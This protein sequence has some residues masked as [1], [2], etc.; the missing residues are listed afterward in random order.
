MKLLTLLGDYLTQRAK[1]SVFSVLA[2]IGP[3]VKQLSLGLGTIVVG[4][5]CFLFTLFF[6]SLSFFFFLI[7]HADWSAAGLWTAFVTALIGL[8]LTLVGRSILTQSHRVLA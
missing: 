5:V 4:I 7:D 8:I 6:L 3:L 1:G 2:P